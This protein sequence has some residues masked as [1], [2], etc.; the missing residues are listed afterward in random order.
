[1]KWEDLCS[2]RGSRN[3][4]ELFTHQNDLQTQRS[5]RPCSSSLRGNKKAALRTIPAEL[6]GA[7]GSLNGTESERESWRLTL[8]GSESADQE[9]A[10]ENADTSPAGL[11]PESNTC[12]HV[13]SRQD[14]WLSTS[15]R[16]QVPPAACHAKS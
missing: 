10:W 11:S 1:M 12:V 15:Q 8:P 9:A 2:G 7:S 4:A 13:T 6:R 16:M 5:P 3:I 14:S